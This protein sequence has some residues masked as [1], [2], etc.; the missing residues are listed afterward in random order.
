MFIPN[1]RGDL[2]RKSG[3]DIY[4]RAQ[5]GPRQDCP[6]AIINLEIG[7]RKTSVRADSSASRGA[8]DE[9]ASQRAK[10]LIPS[11]VDVRVGDYFGFQGRRYEI[12]MVHPRHSIT[13]RF[14]HYECELEVVPE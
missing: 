11:Y 14:D 9:I 4:G 1:L 10:I 7:A 6:F 8:A 13:G 3:R 2:Y 5:L 12:N